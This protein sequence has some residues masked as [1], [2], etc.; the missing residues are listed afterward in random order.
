[1]SDNFNNISAA[2]YE[3]ISNRAYF[4]RTDVATT[5]RGCQDLT[6]Q[7]SKLNDEI[8]RDFSD[9]SK[10]PADLLKK[11]ERLIAL[12][13]QFEEIESQLNEYLP[14]IGSS[15]LTETEKN[16]IKGLYASGLYNQ[17]QLANQYGVSQPTISDIVKT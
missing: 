1:M 2:P 5:K 16:Q 11:R 12:K 4:S 9:R 3:Q 10:D 6:N 8:Y 7:I 13:D 15:R 14:Q 17:Q